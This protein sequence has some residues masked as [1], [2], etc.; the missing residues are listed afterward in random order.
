ME[1]FQLHPRLEKDSFLVERFDK[2][3]IRLLNDCRWPWL[4]LIPQ[5]NGLSELHDLTITDQ[6]QFA[7]RT[8]H[9]AKAMMQLTKCEKINSGVL[10]NV[11]PQLHIHV[12]ARNEGDPNWPNPVWGFETAKP[13]ADR[14]RDELIVKLRSVL[15]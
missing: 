8:N 11:V 12:I 6:K 10:G 4:L 3:Q 1:S 13:Y 2:Y 7:L 5:Q 15:T 9:C 14:D